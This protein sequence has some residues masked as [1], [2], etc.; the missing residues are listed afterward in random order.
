MHELVLDDF[1]IGCSLV[2]DRV[3]LLSLVNFGKSNDNLVFPDA[4]C[5]AEGFTEIEFR[6]PP[7]SRFVPGIQPPKG[8]TP[9]R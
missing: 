2:D 3:P 1:M 7:L 6:V 9:N 5:H 8:G 4:K